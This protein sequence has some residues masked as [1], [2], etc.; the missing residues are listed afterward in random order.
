MGYR[1]LLVVEIV[2]FTTG[3]TTNPRWLFVWDFWLPSMVGKIKISHFTDQVRNGWEKFG[4]V[5]MKRGKCHFFFLFEKV[6]DLKLFSVVSSQ[7]STFGLIF[8]E[9][10]GKMVVNLCNSTISMGSTS[11]IHFFAVTFWGT[12]HRIHGTGIFTYIYHNNQPN[13]GKYTIHGSYGHGWFKHQQWSHGWTCYPRVL[14]IWTLVKKVPAYYKTNEDPKNDGGEYEVN[15]N[16]GGG[17][18]FFFFTPTWGNDPI[19]L[20]FFKWVETTNWI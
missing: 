10:A 1:L 4:L 20:V 12:S 9:N 19:W 13:V 6:G 11:R 15:I 7:W 17:L 8:F 3:F 14:G 5:R 18:I 2:L 16:L